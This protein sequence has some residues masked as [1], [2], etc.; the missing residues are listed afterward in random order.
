MNIKKPLKNIQIQSNLICFLAYPSLLLQGSNYI[1]L[2]YY[3]SVFLV[4][5]TTVIENSVSIHYC[6]ELDISERVDSKKYIGQHENVAKRLSCSFYK[7][8]TLDEHCF[9]NWNSLFP[10][11]LVLLSIRFH[12]V[13]M[14]LELLFSHLFFLLWSRLQLVNLLVI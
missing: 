2:I 5:G 8:F 10:S 13:Q 7:L 4:L 1:I 6:Y 12:I 14:N 3:Y 9:F 11:L